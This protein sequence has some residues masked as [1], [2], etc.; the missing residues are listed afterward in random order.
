M[1]LL[2]LETATADC[3]VALLVDGR[4]QSVAS[5]GGERPSEQVP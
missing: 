5:V 1:R 3:S 2:A 4:V